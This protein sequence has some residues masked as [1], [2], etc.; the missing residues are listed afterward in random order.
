M[1]PSSKTANYLISTIYCNNNVTSQKNV[2]S[3]KTFYN[4]TFN[5]FPLKLSKCNIIVTK[6]K[7]FK[8]SA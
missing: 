1:E 2:I 8:T 4:E 6:R 3:F 7:L 5:M